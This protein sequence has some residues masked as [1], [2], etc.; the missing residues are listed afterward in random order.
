MPGSLVTV[1]YLF[2]A[3]LFILSLSGLSA[4]ESARR[5][6]VFGIVSASYTD[7][8]GAGGTPPISTTGQKNIRQKRQEVENAVT[9]SGRTE[10]A[11]P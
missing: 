1:A 11:I 9:Q 2:A 10:C 7:L 8:G 5:G 6:N 4:Q 3:V